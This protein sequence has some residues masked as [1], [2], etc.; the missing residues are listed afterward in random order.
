M[1]LPNMSPCPNVGLRDTEVI[2]SKQSSD[3]IYT[4]EDKLFVQCVCSCALRT[5]RLPQTLYSLSGGVSTVITY[6]MQ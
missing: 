5:C 2:S 4:L 3:T 6:D 1:T